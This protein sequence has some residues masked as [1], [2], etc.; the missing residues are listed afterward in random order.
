MS[1]LNNVIYLSNANFNTLM[2]TG[3]VTIDGT[4]LTY[5]P[6]SIYITPDEYGIHTTFSAND[7]TNTST[8]QAVANYVTNKLPTFTLSGGIL[9][10]T[11]NS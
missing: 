4:T 7:N 2:T 1:K 9:T 3:T 6:D 8:D 5:D 10:I 11:D